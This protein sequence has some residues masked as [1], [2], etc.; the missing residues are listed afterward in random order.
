MQKILL[1]GKVL[2]V[3]EASTWHYLEWPF[4]SSFPKPGKGHRRIR[5]AG[6]APLSQ[7]EEGEIVG[8]R[9]WERQRVAE[10]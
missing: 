5:R 10:K 6:L 8:E 2:T 7:N 3:R 1:K 9:D 4:L